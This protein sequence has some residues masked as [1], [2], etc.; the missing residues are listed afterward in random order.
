MRALF[1]LLLVACS[2][3]SMPESMPTTDTAI[4]DV[5]PYADIVAIVESCTTRDDL[6]PLPLYCIDGRIVAPTPIV[7]PHESACLLVADWVAVP[8]M[9]RVGSLDGF[10]MDYID[11]LDWPTVRTPVGRKSDCLR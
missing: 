7:M 10:A 4:A 2:V 3:E 6:R 9:Q 11:R 5:W 8:D 1:L